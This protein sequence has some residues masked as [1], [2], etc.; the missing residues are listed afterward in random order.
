MLY[1]ILQNGVCENEAFGLAAK[2]LNHS[3]T[4]Y[5]DPSEVNI[6]EFHNKKTYIRSSLDHYL[7]HWRHTEDRLRPGHCFSPQDFRYL[8]YQQYWKDYLYNKNFI[9]API[10]NL[11]EEWYQEYIEGRDMFIRPNSGC[12]VFPGQVILSWSDLSKLLNLYRPP[13]EELAIF[14]HASPIKDE[15]RLVVGVDSNEKPTIISGSMYRINGEIESKRIFPKCQAWE[16]AQSVV[17]KVLDRYGNPPSNIFTIDVCSERW[18][19]ELYVVE[20]NSFSCAG[21]YDCEMEPIIK[22][23]EK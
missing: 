18:R 3:V 1:F 12:K 15:A 7:L 21:L 17:N 22:Y 14:S 20:I 5:D 11:T 6:I 4:F 23:L 16:F 10:S 2:N 19:E 13:L 8:N 9:A